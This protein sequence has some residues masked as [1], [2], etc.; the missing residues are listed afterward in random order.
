MRKTIS[1]TKN[2][3]PDSFDWHDKEVANSIKN[4][5][6][7]GSYWPFSSIATSESAY[8][9][10]TDNLLQNLLDCVKIC[11]EY[12]GSWP[13]KSLTYVIEKQNGQFISKSDYLYK[14]IEGLSS[15][16]SSKAI[17]KITKYI[18][19][20]TSNENN[21]KE[22][23]TA[24]GAAPIC[25]AAGNMPFMSYTGGIFDDNYRTIMN[26]AVATVGYGSEGGID[27]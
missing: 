3:A 18:S 20:E 13:Y 7:C 8:A 17:S 23:I 5:G 15:Y 11:F 26:H 4:Q 16:D 6:N 9:I 21:L 10:K 27:F 25:T 19:V 24:Y 1:G 22:K 2:A 12:N 14:D